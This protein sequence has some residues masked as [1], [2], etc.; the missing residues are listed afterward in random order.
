MS[1]FSDHEI[2]KQ[3]FLNSAAKQ[4][5]LL[6]KISNT[7]RIDQVIIDY[8]YCGRTQTEFELMKSVLNNIQISHRHLR[9]SY[10]WLQLHA[11][12]SQ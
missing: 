5:S 11:A 9:R 1:F 2:T 12:A 6:G 8:F 7:R 3:S 4:S 10:A